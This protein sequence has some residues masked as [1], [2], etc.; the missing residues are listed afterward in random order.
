MDE[1]EGL[2]VPI[3]SDRHVEILRNF[4]KQ[5]LTNLG[6]SGVW[7]QPRKQREDQWIF[8]GSCL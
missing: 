3:S 2:A 8:G 6:N 7:F 1:E 5:N 4:L